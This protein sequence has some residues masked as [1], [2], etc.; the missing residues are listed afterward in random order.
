MISDFRNIII[1]EKPI[2]IKNFKQT[3]VFS[4]NILFS[5]FKL[6]FFDKNEIT[7]FRKGM[8]NR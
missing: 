2:P 1:T 6:I 8:K 4:Q 7:C 3:A 5:E